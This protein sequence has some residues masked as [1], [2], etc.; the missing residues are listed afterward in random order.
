MENVESWSKYR[1]Y[2]A[3]AWRFRYCYDTC[4]LPLQLPFSLPLLEIK[5]ESVTV[6][7]T[8]TADV[9]CRCSITIVIKHEKGPIL[10]FRS[11][12]TMVQK[13]H[14]IRNKSRLN[15]R[16]K[17]C[18]C[19]KRFTDI[20]L[21]DTLN[22]KFTKLNALFEYFYHVIQVSFKFT[23]VSKMLYTLWEHIAYVIFLVH[24]KTW[25]S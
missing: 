17:D 22:D 24:T 19:K 21:S 11:L 12:C 15:G 9:T 1:I 3:F 8:K 7:V 6:T 20:K 10:N 13:T 16:S 2:V 14:K 25:N 4:V 23:L 5:T 18:T